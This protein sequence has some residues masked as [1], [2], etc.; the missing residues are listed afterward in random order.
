MKR[1][2]VII[3]LLFYGIMAVFCNSYRLKVATGEKTRADGTTFH[4]WDRTELSEQ[5]FNK[6]KDTDFKNAKVTKKGNATHYSIEKDGD[7]YGVYR[8]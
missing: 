3:T 6:L 4:T 8:E 5:S 1:G 2:I 7:E